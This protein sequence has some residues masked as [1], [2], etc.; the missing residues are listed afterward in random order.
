MLTAAG[1][2]M[3]DISD[4]LRI[5]IISLRLLPVGVATA[6]HLSRCHELHVSRIFMLETLFHTNLPIFPALGMA[7]VNALA[8]TSLTEV[9]N[10]AQGHFLMA[11]AG[12][13]DRSTGHG[14]RQ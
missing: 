14:C 5:I 8:V 10:V 12:V 6:D 7:I 9:K 2:H 11:N 13:T 3:I 1:S 4:I